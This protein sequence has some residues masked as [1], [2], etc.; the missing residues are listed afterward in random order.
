MLGRAHEHVTRGPA[1]ARRVKGGELAGFRSERRNC[2]LRR[3]PRNLLPRHI[4][5]PPGS[6][7][8]AL[9]VVRAGSS[10]SLE[11]RGYALA[12]TD[13]HGLHRVPATCP[14]QLTQCFD[15]KDGAGGTDGVLERDTAAVRVGLVRRFFFFKQKTAYEITR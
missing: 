13:A 8:R 9:A 4:N 12:A 11:D 15:N 10:H 5:G 1:E 2:R 6:R 14:P 7:L 3:F